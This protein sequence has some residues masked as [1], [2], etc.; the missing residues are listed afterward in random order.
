MDAQGALAGLKVIEFVGL[1]P[2][3]FG[4]MLLADLGATV[5]GILRPG[6]ER[7]ALTENRD[8]ISLDLRDPESLAAV[9]ELIDE[10]D[11]LIEGFRPGA[12]ERLGIG[13]EVLCLHNERLIYSRM[14]GWGQAGPRSHTA[15]HDLTYIAIT[16]ALH[17]A[18]R[19]QGL[20]T[21]PANLLGDFGAG[22][23]Y[24]VTAVLAAVIERG[25]TGRGQVLDI[26]I[27]DATT[28]LTSMIHEYRADGRWSDDAGTNR[29]DTGAPYYDVYPCSDG[30]F[31]AVAALEDAFFLELLHVLQID[32]DLGYDRLDPA[33]WAHLRT[34]LGNVFRQRTRDE[35]SRIARDSDACIAPV[36]NLGEA[37]RD[38]HLVSREVLVE[39]SSTAGW[40]PRLPLGYA[41][42]A[43]DIASVLTSWTTLTPQA[44]ALLTSLETVRSR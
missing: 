28:Y 6:V 37:P 22:G 33:N 17:L 24:L 44:R 21:P 35:W 18:T 25:R 9:R 23:F 29:L 2:A 10:A 39:R 27:V 13:P 32:P 31:V 4:A 20:P 19:D 30:K 41:E 3:P 16:G 38:D 5:V 43:K 11:V 12:M 1:G 7:P 34:L 36:L 15:G 42:A 26:G 40:R 14:T 8:L